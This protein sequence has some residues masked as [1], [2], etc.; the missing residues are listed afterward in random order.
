MKAAANTAAPVSMDRAPMDRTSWKELFFNLIDDAGPALDNAVTGEEEAGRLS[1]ATLAFLRDQ[2]FLKLKLPAELGGAEADNALQFEVYERIAYHNVAASWCAFIYTDLIAL[3]GS[4]LG[5]QG[6]DAMFADG[7]PLVCG[8]GGRL[9]GDVVPVD[10][11]YMVSGKF[12]YGSGLPGS[13]WTAVMAMDK[14][15]ADAPVLMCAIPSGKVQSLENWDVFGLRA[16]ASSDFTVTETFVPEALTI[17]LGTPPLRGGPQFTLG[18]TGLISHTIPGVALGVTRRV[19]DDLASLAKDKQRGYTSR[20]TIGDRPAFQAFMARAD[21]RVKS[22]RALMIENGLRL[23]AQAATGQGT[24][25]VEAEARAAG[26]YATELAVEVI[27]EALRWAGG[28]AIRRGTRF[29]S[30]LR[31]IN[32]ASTHYCL[33]NTSLESH[34]QYLLGHADV[35]VEA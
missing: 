20:L 5:Q 22:A 14:T 28:E 25:E 15:L 4:S 19:L 35:A 26:T 27:T 2:D 6:L 24:L 17:E 9:I 18:T 34:G 30:A 31:D 7:L 12:A 33:N 23:S 11:G 32:V 16:T 13:D 3:F 8:G 29:E 10:G 21:L 1:A